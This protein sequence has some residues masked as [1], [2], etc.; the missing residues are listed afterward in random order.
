[1]ATA[2][3]TQ[4]QTM[5]LELEVHDTSSRITLQG[6][7]MS[8]SDQESEIRDAEELSRVRAFILV[9]T[10]SGIT[11][12]GSMSGGLLTVCLP[13]IAKDLNLPDNLLLCLA[14]GCCLLLAGSLADFLG[15]RSINLVGCFLLAGFILACGVAETGIQL[16]MFRTL[17]GIAT[18]MCLPTAFS[19]LTDSMST[20][21]RRNIGFACL[22]LGQPLGFS[23]GLVL[24]GIFQDSTLGWR[25]G[26]YLCAGAT[27]L[28]TIVNYF[29]LP[30]DR[31][32]ECFSFSRLRTEIDWVGIVLSSACLGIISYVFSNITDHPKSIR[33]ASNIA[34]LSVAAAMIPSFWAWMEWRE[35]SGRPAL[36]PNSLWKNRA[37]TT[38]C[39]MVFFSWAVLNG[40]ET[41]LSLFFQEVQGLSALQAALRFLPNVI[42]GMIINLGTGLLIHRVRAN[43]LVLV[44]S[45]LS[46][47][48]PLLMALIDPKWSWWYDIFWVMLLGPV[49]ADVANL[50]IADSF[51]P[52]TQGLAGAVFNTVAQ[53]GT[54]IGLSVFA[55]ISAGVTDGSHYKNKSSPDALMVGYRAVFWACFGLL[56]AATAISAW[57]LRRVGKVGIKRE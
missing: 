51:S 50:I 3:Y 11:F 9:A 40:M 36:I 57:G 6:S 22:G 37:F 30:T 38:I 43:Y 39:V 53:F 31:P 44:T 34:L 7:Q 23:V 21:K 17:Q 26:Y 47:G 15:N 8:A 4:S 32:R 49:S 33:N 54:S 24:G 45:V 56:L 28:L 55:I 13:G 19:I 25:F 41:I 14:N 1:M 48:S 5:S 16:I 27:F 20:G 29:K 12:V 42:I 35:K 46:A 52:K 18:S 2:V 10:L